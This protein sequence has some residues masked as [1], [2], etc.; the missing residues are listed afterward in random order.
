[1]YIKKFPLKMWKNLKNQIAPP[2]QTIWKKEVICGSLDNKYE[3][4]KLTGCSAELLLSKK[5][6]YKKIIDLPSGQ[7]ISIWWL[8]PCCGTENPIP[9]PE[10]DM[11]AKIM[12]KSEWLIDR[13]DSIVNE[14][15]MDKTFN[16]GITGNSAEEFLAELEIT[17][18]ESY[19][20]ERDQSTI[21][22]I[23]RSPISE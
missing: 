15:L 13:R 7:N 18:P 11:N 22:L 8:C 10:I 6:F 19:L 17:L 12:T 9:I 21:K 20:E 16:K 14:L 23:N 4:P 1:M 5:D 2:L 3:S